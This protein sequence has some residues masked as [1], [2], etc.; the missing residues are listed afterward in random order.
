MS[1]PI[2]PP[3]PIDRLRE[4]FSYNPETGLFTRRA[5]V[6]GGRYPAG[7]VAGSKTNNGYIVV[8]I[9]GCLYFAHRLAWYFVY[10][11]WP[12]EIDHLN[13]KSDDNRIANLRPASHT[14]NIL[15]SKLQVGSRSGITGVYNDGPRY[16]NPWARPPSP[17]KH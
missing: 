15:N 10:G 12:E 17:P 7:V 11:T 6:G 1:F 2:K 16:R 4:L 8:R 3:P 5:A 13:H 9:D 14:L